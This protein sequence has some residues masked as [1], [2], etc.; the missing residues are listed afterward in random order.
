MRDMFE[1]LGVRGKGLGVCGLGLGGA[2]VGDLSSQV[3][4]L[5][6]KGRS[7]IADLPLLRDGN[8]I[9]LVG[10]TNFRPNTG[11]KSAI[12]DA[13]FRRNIAYLLIF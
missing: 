9:Q 6:P 3:G 5:S 2:V 8:L 7:A 1:G 4:D 13:M 12:A 11:S 10:N